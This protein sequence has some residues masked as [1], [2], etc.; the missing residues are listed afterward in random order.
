MLV[1]VTD[2]SRCDA[3]ACADNKKERTVY[4]FECRHKTCWS[5]FRATVA[6][7]TASGEGA[8][9]VC[10]QKAGWCVFNLSD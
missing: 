7:G 1:K 9:G 8:C 10:G 2:K 5:H 4:R 3:T 6:S